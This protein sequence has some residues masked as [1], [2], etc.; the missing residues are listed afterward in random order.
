MPDP[1]ADFTLSD[2]PEGPG[3]TLAESL[4]LLPPDLRAELRAISHDRHVPQGTVV[5][6]QGSDAGEVGFIVHGTL[7]MRKLMPD[8]H[9]HVIGLLVPTDIFGRLFDGP[10]G[11]DL[12]ALNDTRLIV[13]ERSGFEAIM[14]RAPEVERIFLVSLLDELDAAR[15]WFMMLSGRKVLE[16]VASF[17]LILLRRHLKNGLD[18]AGPGPHVI[19]LPLKR[20]DLS[21]YLGIRP[22]SL[23][24]SLHDLQNRGVV[25]IRDPYVLEILDIRLLAMVSGPDMRLD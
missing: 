24:R 18:G 12:V 23:S 14:R 2:L 22:E 15:E 9:D 5:V 6:A 20:S 21:Q 7:A 25:R 4:N 8:D 11:Y 1:Q 17:L 13:F 10:S 16:R 19:E 3:K